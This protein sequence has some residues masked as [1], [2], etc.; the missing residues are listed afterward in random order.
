MKQERREK[1]TQFWGSLPSEEKTMILDSRDELMKQ[2]REETLRLLPSLKNQDVLEIGGGIGRLTGHLADQ[3]NTLVCVDII[4]K[5]L[6]KNW[7]KNKDRKNIQY[8][9]SDAMDLNFAPNQFDFVFI[10]WLLMYL[11]DKEVVQLR[12]RI[13]RWLKSEGILF[14]R[15]S[16]HIKSVALNGIGFAAFRQLHNYTQTFDVK[17]RMLR[18]DH[19]R[20]YVDLIAD[21]YQCY[22]IYQKEKDT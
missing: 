20:C 11:K 1:T 16:C 13:F 6:V 2:D 18:Q 15:E 17:F 14:F 8:I 3:A 5:F 21:P 12:D 9:L 19:F 4:E 10:N 7:E 22:W